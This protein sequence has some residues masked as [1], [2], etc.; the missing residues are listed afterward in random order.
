MTK[1]TI[2]R[3]HDKKYLAVSCFGHAEY[4]DAGEDIVCAAISILV[5]NT[6]NAI[7]VFTSDEIS[8]DA[9]EETGLLNL[10]FMQP[11]GHDSELLLDTMVLGLQKIQENYGDKYL[12]LDFREV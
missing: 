10:K 3:N 2:F 9:E 1:I 12:I 11:A 8:E 6:F 4:A 7:E 5:I